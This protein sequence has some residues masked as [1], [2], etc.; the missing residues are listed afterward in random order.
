M[1]TV[2]YTQ[3]QPFV[4]VY[5]PDCPKALIIEAIRQACIEFCQY[6]RYWR[7]ELDG[8]YTVATDS[9]YE[10]ITPTDSTIADILVIKVNKEPIEAKTQDD[11]ESIYSEWREQN[12]KPKYFFMRDKTSIVFVPIP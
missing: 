10:L 1:A 8:F 4:Q 9:E 12:G 6:S 5:V 11:L 3:W 2:S 7:K